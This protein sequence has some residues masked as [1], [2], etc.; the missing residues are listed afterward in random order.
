MDFV[1]DAMP[2]S[3]GILLIHFA[4]NA[5]PIGINLKKRNIP[6]SIVTFVE[7]QYKPHSLNHPAMIVTKKQKNRADS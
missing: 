3:I 7:N 4:I 6:K 1:F 5:S 2:K